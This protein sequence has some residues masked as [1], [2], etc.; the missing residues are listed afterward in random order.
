MEKEVRSCTFRLEHHRLVSGR[1]NLGQE[2]PLCPLILHLKPRHR[3]L[4][5]LTFTAFPFSLSVILILLCT[6]LAR[7]GPSAG[8][9][10]SLTRTI[11][12]Q[13]SLHSSNICWAAEVE[14]SAVVRPQHWWTGVLP[15]FLCWSMENKWTEGLVNWWVDGF[16]KWDALLSRSR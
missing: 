16:R 8:T 12:T 11:H 3:G 14:G 1:R 2:E 4:T 7:Q 9:H 13:S 6:A 5:P 10:L 15:S